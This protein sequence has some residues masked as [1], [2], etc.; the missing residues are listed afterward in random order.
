MKKSISLLLGAGFSAPMGYPVGSQLKED[1]LKL[2][3]LN[4]AGIQE[5]VVKCK[6]HAISDSKESFQACVE[7]IRFFNNRLK[8]FNYEAFYDF[9]LPIGIY[10]DAIRKVRPFSRK[11]NSTSKLA[12]QSGDGALE[13]MLSVYIPAVYNLLILYYLKIDRR[14]GKENIERDLYYENGPE[15]AEEYKCISTC[16]SH[17]IENGDVHVHTLN[18]DLLF[19]QFGKM[20][21][22]DDKISDGF[23]RE[24][25][26]YRSNPHYDTNDLHQ[27]R[28]Y[29]GQYKKP[30]KLYKLHGSIDQLWFNKTVDGRSEPEC[31]VKIDSSSDM[32]FIGK[33]NENG[34][35]EGHPGQ[36]YPDFLTGT[37][38]K[39]NRYSEQHYKKLLEH[40]KKNLQY[41]EKLIIIGYGGRD[42]EVNRIILE[43]FD[44]Q[45]K[46]SYI[47]DPYA[48]DAVKELRSKLGAK[49]I[50]K[51]LK[52]LTIVD[53]EGGTE[54]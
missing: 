45:T 34:D 9:L 46:P 17:F 32:K 25:S 14:V 7:L 48:G 28:R 26:L 21:L 13:N 12:E 23:E 24:S 37:T 10:E 5:V 50:E 4:E 6:L 19:E 39:I 52:A 49:L 47:I 16:L 8:D 1:L 41:A 3:T 15:L 36:F 53:I 29:T 20:G 54:L 38:S 35:Y 27:L 31:Y 44:Y 30:C 2:L 40:F 43:H 33:L 51:Q 22:L 11:G 42:E 18:H